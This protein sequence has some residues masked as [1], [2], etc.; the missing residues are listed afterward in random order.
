MATQNSVFLNQDYRRLALNSLPWIFSAAMIFAL[1][2]LMLSLQNVTEPEENSVIVRRI[3]TALPPPPPPPPPIEIE[4]VETESEAPTIDLIGMGNGPSMRYSDTP[5]LGKVN[6]EKVKKPKFDLSSLNFEKTISLDF[7]VIEVKNLDR[8]PRVV[9]VR[10]PSI[11]RALRSRGITFVPVKVD[12]IID[13]T[14]RAYIKR[15][16]DPVYPE[17]ITPIR[18]WVSSVRFTVPTKNGRPVQAIYHYTLNFRH[19]T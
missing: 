5:V 7:P 15:I 9:S 17:M 14:G 11:P 19:R 12:I 8:Q 18:Q 2:G 3:D 16:V 6:I 4:Q 10:N 13:D 1:L